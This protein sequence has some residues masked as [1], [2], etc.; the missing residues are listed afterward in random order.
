MVIPPL[1]TEWKIRAIEIKRFVVLH[2]R[3]YPIELM[4]T[5]LPAKDIHQEGRAVD[6]HRAVQ[7][8]ARR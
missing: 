2:D 8:D 1:D 7:F 3:T 4:V 5:Q 6:W